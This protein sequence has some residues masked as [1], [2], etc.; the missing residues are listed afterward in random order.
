MKIK[1]FYPQEQFFANKTVQK[2]QIIEFRQEV[3]GWDN[4]Q[5]HVET[6]EPQPPRSLF[7]T[8]PLFCVWICQEHPA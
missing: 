1:D 8:M 5:V 6:K 7:Y 4:V 3:E 2:I